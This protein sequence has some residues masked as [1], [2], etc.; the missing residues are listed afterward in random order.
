MAGLDEAL[1]W[2]AA[3]ALRGRVGRDQLRM[4]GLEFFEF[5]DELVEFGVADFGIVED[6]VAVFVV[7]DLVAQG[8][9]LFLY[10][11]W[12][13]VG[14]NYSDSSQFPVLSSQLAFRFLFSRHITIRVRAWPW[15]LRKT[16]K[17]HL[18]G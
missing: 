4:L 2:L 12:R 7:A 9:D 14:G 11:G 15:S 10:C 18:W 3:Y 5:V 17:R 13:H 1:A 6:V 16:P 8:F